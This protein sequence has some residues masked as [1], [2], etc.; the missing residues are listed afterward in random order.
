MR[1]VPGAVR[2]GASVIDTWEGTTMHRRTTTTAAA[3]C[4]AALAAGLTTIPAAAVAPH[5]GPSSST[6]GLP[7][8]AI[9]AAADPADQEAVR[10]ALREAAAEAA[11]QVAVQRSS[12]SATP[13]DVPGPTRLPSLPRPDLDAALDQIVADG[14]IGVTATVETST[15]RWSDA[16]GTRDLDG[17]APALERSPLRV[18]SNTKMMVAT[19]VMQEVEAGTWTLDTRVDDVIPGLFPDHPE[20]TIRHLLSHTSGMPL[21]TYEL[22][23]PYAGTDPEDWDAFVSAIG[24]DYTDAEHIDAVN[25]AP[26]VGEPGAQFSYSNAGYVALGMLLE[27][28]TGEEVE[29]LVDER[30]RRPAGMGQTRVLDEPGLRGPAL[31]EAMFVDGRGWIGLE[32]FDPDV[33]SH[34][35]S[36]L[37][38]VEDLD[39]LTRAL[40]SGDLVS[41]ASVEQM[42]TPS[43]ENPL[44]YGLGTYAIPDPCRPGEFL[45]GHDGAS[46]GS[47]SLAL[48]SRDGTRQLALGVTGRDLTVAQD[49]LYDLNDL[50]VP[51]LV[52][53]C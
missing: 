16:A 4:A 33:F 3:A 40:M 49:A 9:G 1:C 17:Q 11:T 28:V 36:A 34:S 47:L 21:G 37:S 19:L 38:T 8:G 48:S 39:D 52:A 32:G 26:W 43:S 42:V 51:M 45:H 29:A 25:A 24:R 20:V 41:E 6:A 53:T 18:A 27:E 15:L 46:F 5:E 2:L 31:H 44:G 50:L 10:E 23:T 7:V 13:Q 35:G 22:I 14:A 12:P 30:I